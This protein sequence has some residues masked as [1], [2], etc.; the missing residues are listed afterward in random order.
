MNFTKLRISV[1]QYILVLSIPYLS[2]QEYIPMDFENGRWFVEVF[3]KGGYQEWIQ[4]Y[5]KGDT[6]IDGKEYHKLYLNKLSLKP[7]Q[8]FDEMDTIIG[9]NFGAIRNGENKQVLFKN[10]IF[11]SVTVI[12]DFNLSVGDTIYGLQDNFIV[13]SIDSVEYCGKYHKRYIQRAGGGVMDE[14]L[15]EGIGFSTGLLGYLYQYYNFE[16]TRWL[17]CYTEKGNEECASCDNL[18][19]V[20]D[21][22]IKTLIYPIPAKDNVVIK[23]TKPI[24]RVRILDLAGITVLFKDYDDLFFIEESIA[25]FLKGMYVVEVYFNDHSKKTTQLIK[26]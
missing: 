6:I 26:N 3:Q 13:N 14:T 20:S 8:E 22:D 2:G 9:W 17:Y 15:T 1:V 11:D 4:Y 18:L 24:Y 12:Y 23:S 7:N 16:N 19:S 25:G 10:P 21:I 5:C